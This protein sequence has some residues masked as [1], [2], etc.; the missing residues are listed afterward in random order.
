MGGGGSEIGLWEITEMNS[1]VA[2][3]G[4]WVAVGVV[5]RVVE[6][7]GVLGAHWI[8][9][10]SFKVSYLFTTKAIW[11]N[12]RV[13]YGESNYFSI[14]PFD[15]SNCREWLR[16]ISSDL[17]MSNIYVDHS[18]HQLQPDIPEDLLHG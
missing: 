17:G 7:E 18:T 9:G 8:L 5:V 13:V 10:L 6:L 2:G 12:P 11:K 14:L 15:L 3:L 4:N 16:A 1:E